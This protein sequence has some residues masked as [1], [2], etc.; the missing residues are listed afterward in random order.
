MEIEEMDK[1]KHNNKYNIIGG[2]LGTLVGASAGYLG[3]YLKALGGNDFHFALLN[4]FPSMIA[5][6]VLIPGAMIIDSSKNKLKTTLF[7]CFISRIFFILY[8]LIPALPKEFQA[9]GL[10]VLMGLRNA[11][12]AI[13]GIGY[14]SLV[15]DVFP[16]NK[17]NSIIGMR[18]KYNNILSMGATFLLGTFLTLNERFLIDLLLLY[19]I[20]FIFTFGV[21][22]IE[23]LQ[24]RNF[25]FEPKQIKKTES[26]AKKFFNTIKSLPKHPK[27]IKYCVTVIIFY[28]GWQMTQPLYNIYQLDVLKAN[29]AWIGYLGIAST[30][31]QFLTTTMWMKLA[32][33]IGSRVILGVCMS[34]MAL[35]PFV[36]AISK[37]LPMLLAMQLIVGS[38]MSG[39][40]TLLFN[41]LIGVSPEENRTLYIS[42]FTCLTQLTSSFMPFVGIIIK[43]SFSIQIA[44]YTSAAIRL[45]GAI[46]FL[47]SFRNERQAEN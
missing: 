17:L 37:T 9:I 29:E 7:I 44:L 25:V 12:E 10:V 11:P 41:E 22:V 20:L 39:A 5:V 24:Y 35:S 16:I 30:L 28:L 47:W 15:A 1:L 23:I 3:T 45:I 34:L 42:L 46:V 18:S 21:G 33:K 19:K 27:Y 36:Y 14:Q 4:A 13:W 2:L 40:I 6:L 8:A 26:F 32:D 43:R 38:G 31:V